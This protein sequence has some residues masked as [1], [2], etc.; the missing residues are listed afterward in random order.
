MPTK[1]QKYSLKPKRERMTENGKRFVGARV[2]SILF[3]KWERFCERHSVTSTSALEVAMSEFL[4]T[5]KDDP[6]E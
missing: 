2:D 5:H 1:T 6:T 3:N 4:E